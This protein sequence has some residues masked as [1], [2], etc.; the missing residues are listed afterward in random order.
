MDGLSVA[1]SVVAV[2]Q[3]ATK[4]GSACQQYYFCAKGARREIQRIV[5]G[6][7]SLTDIL[8]NLK[9]LVESPGGARLAASGL[10][11][12]ADGPLQKC[13]SKLTAIQN[14]LDAPP[15][16]KWKTLGKSL[17]WPFQEKE[18]SKIIA[19]IE[20]HKQDLGLALAVDNT[21]IALTTGDSVAEL[22][23]AVALAQLDVKRNAILSWLTCTDPSKNQIAARQKH[24]PSTGGWL[25]KRSEF[26]RWKT[27][28]NS[29][30]W[31]HGKGMLTGEDI[32][33]TIIDYIQFRCEQE[34]G[35]AIA[36]FYFDFNDTGKQDARSF[37]SSILVQLCRQRVDTP[38]TLQ[39]LYKR[40]QNGHQRPAM[41]GLL[42]ALSTTLTVFTHV[43]LILDALDECPRTDGERGRLLKL[44]SDIRSWSN[45]CVHM[46]ATSRREI[47]IEEAMEIL[48]VEAPICIEEAAVSDDIRTHIN[49][50]LM[51]V[52][53]NLWPIKIKEEV[54]SVLSEQAG[55]MF[56]WV[57]CQLDVLQ[58]YSQPSKIRKALK[59]LPKTL[60]A[61][62]D[63]MLLGIA[64]DCQDQALTALKWLAFSAR[65]LLITELAE[66][67]VVNPEE[68]PSFDSEDRLFAPLEILRFLPG[69]VTMSSPGGDEGDKEDR[70]ENGKE[71]RLAHFSVKEY[72]ISQRICNGPAQE[73][74][75]TEITANLSI[76][77][78]C[79]LYILQACDSDSPVERI[80]QEYPLLGYAAQYWPQHVRVVDQAPP[81][82]LDR[83]G[84]ELLWSQTICFLNWVLIYNPDRKGWGGPDYAME[85][86]DIAS[87][88]YYA[89][90]LGLDKLVRLLLDRGAEVNAE[91]GLY[92][93]AL[94]AALANGHEKIA[95]LLLGRG[96]D[97]NAQGGKYGAA[98]Q[99]ASRYGSKVARVLLDRGANTNARG[100][101]YG[102]AL[103]A[104]S[105]HGHEE[106]A[107][108]LLDRGADVNAWSGRYGT[109]LQMA[110]GQDQE[111][112]VQLLLDRGADV[113]IHNGLGTP[114]YTA[115][116][117]GYEK[118]VQLLLDR[119]ADPNTRDAWHRTALQTALDNGHKKIAKLLLDQ[120]ADPEIDK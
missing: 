19:G 23:N 115:S 63:R 20:K 14:K 66:A 86:R 57:V 95:Q 39:D 35:S 109:A 49:S 105:C 68:D 77:E 1:A 118:V 71:I 60:D 17:V 62:Y 11:T 43:Y 12:E 82:S 3:L 4:V 101:V 98:L 55:G 107:Q 120:G 54:E 58:N 10:L 106:V 41:G 85:V 74:S 56:R 32:S 18:V 34:P 90:V 22:R 8:D 92:G 50:R 91:G 114:L 79:L 46:L 33:S 38:D 112:V 116:C 29:L 87:P 108:L 64:E 104:A 31:L 15:G 25:M 80:L 27:A 24:E 94:Q 84:M 81:A 78:M 70:G 48:L 16:G 111:E 28:P 9:D 45:A 61:T 76:A 99:A 72:L 113:N 40:C 44:I 97:V 110:S 119:G 65:P 7:A 103:R 69:L 89:S 93:N 75:I 42:A 13:Y 51:G 52:R 47:D 36:Y 117:C 96:A 5:D 59:S 73:Y 83:L 37:V 67:V 53:F 88:L 30:L 6:V 2:I 21:A 100:G 102:T 26:E